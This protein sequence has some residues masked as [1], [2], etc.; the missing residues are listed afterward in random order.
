M[1]AEINEYGELVLI[2]DSETENYA[3]KKWFNDVK[4]PMDDKARNEA[5]F[6]RG[7]KVKSTYV[8]SE[9]VKK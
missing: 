3:L 8:I 7:S 4:V 6:I 2:P 9:G 5:F 1:K